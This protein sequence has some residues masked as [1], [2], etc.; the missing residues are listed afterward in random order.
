VPLNCPVAGWG[1]WALGRRSLSDLDE[2][3]HSLVFVPA[4]SDLA[5]DVEVAGR[6]WTI[7]LAFEEGNGDVGLDECA[8]RSW[9]GWFLHITRAFLAVAR[10]TAAPLPRSGCCPARKG[11]L[12]AFKRQ[13]GLRG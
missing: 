12:A 5:E 3:A 9:T 4:G 6:R 1:R 8:V 2:R 11:S 10:A 13:R 7:E